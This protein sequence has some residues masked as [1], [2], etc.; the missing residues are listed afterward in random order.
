MAR[1]S[2]LFHLARQSDRLAGACAN[3]S[4]H[5]LSATCLHSVYS[6]GRVGPMA[7]VAEAALRGLSVLRF[8]DLTGP[9]GVLHRVHPCACARATLLAR[10]LTA[11]VVA[12]RM[13]GGPDAD[14]P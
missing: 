7:V 13:G 12:R 14:S 8:P 2:R 11:F 10:S 9:S 5:R 3:A 1:G 4:A 6:R